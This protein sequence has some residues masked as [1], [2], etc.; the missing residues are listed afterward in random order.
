MGSQVSALEQSGIV[1]RKNKKNLNTHT[2]TPN[3]MSCLSLSRLFLLLCL[4]WKKH[5]QRLWRRSGKI[6]TL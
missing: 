4:T 5:T 1:S 3:P 2:H 6:E